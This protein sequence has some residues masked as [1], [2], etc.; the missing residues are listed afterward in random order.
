[1]AKL[2]NYILIHIHFS[3][4][5]PIEDIAT[6]VVLKPQGVYSHFAKADSGFNIEVPHLKLQEPMEFKLIYSSY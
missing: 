5:N 1:M 3:N 2:V 4:V 6:D